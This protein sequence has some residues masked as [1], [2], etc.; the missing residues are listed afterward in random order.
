MQRF[1]RRS[2]DGAELRNPPHRPL[3]SRSPEPIAQGLSPNPPTSPH[4][5]RRPRSSG[6]GESGQPISPKP[7][8]LRLDPGYPQDEPH[9]PGST[10]AC[11]RR[12]AP[13]ALGLSCPH[14][15]LWGPLF[16]GLGAL[17]V[18]DD[19]TGTRLTTRFLADAVTQ[20]FVNTFPGAVFAPSSKE[21]IDRLVRREVLRQHAPSDAAPAHVEDRVD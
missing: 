5:H 15:T 20:G 9:S 11:Q 6:D 2:S 8:W 3:S 16:R 18:N 4:K 1:S 19:S 10:R 14:R 17:A 21:A 12:C 7:A 13:C